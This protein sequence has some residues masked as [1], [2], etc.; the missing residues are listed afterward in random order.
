MTLVLKTISNV[1]RGTIEGTRPLYANQSECNGADIDNDDLEV[2]SRRQTVS[3]VRALI[4]AIHFF[5]TG[6]P[7]HW[8]IKKHARSCRGCKMTTVGVLLRNSSDVVGW[9]NSIRSRSHRKCIDPG[10]KE[11]SRDRR[12]YPSALPEWHPREFDY[13]RSSTGW[14][15]K[16]SWQLTR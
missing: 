8:P 9:R 4:D 10:P 15:G 3:F 7:T 14:T 16:H 13:K 12:I 6:K 11:K 5:K 2:K 1:D